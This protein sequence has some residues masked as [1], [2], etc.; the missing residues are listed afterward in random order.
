MMRSS[1]TMGLGNC[2]V[3]V[4]VLSAIAATVTSNPYSYSQTPSYNSPGHEHKGPKYV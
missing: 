2:M 1:R 3:Y 4:V